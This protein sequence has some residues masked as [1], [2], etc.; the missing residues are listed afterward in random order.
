MDFLVIFVIVSIMGAALVALVIVWTTNR[1]AASAI[2]RHFKASEYIL[3]TG[4]PPPSW[5][6]RRADPLQ[7]LDKLMRFYEGCN[8]FEDEFAREQLLLQ[9][10]AVR[11]KW[12]R[13]LS[14]R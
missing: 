7:R 6:G 12:S 9:L 2:T 8:F 4:E 3:E 14:Q 5:R 11:E 1:S 13:R 10:Q